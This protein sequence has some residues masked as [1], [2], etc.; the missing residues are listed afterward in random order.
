MIVVADTSPINY[1][2]L[3]DETKVLPALYEK[4]VVPEAVF[5]ELQ[6]DETPERVRNWVINAPTWFTVLPVTISPVEDLP[7]LDEG[8]K[9]AIALFEQI[10][11]DA[12][13]IDERAG[14]E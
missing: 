5:N 7:E 9:Q 11:A 2:V 14:R 1:L 3:I 6:A 8:E 10:N 12:L 13:L 4:I